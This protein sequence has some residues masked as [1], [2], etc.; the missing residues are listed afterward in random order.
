MAIKPKKERDFRAE[1]QRRLQRGRERNLS[2]SQS[3]GHHRAGERDLSGP[4]AHQPNTPLERALRLVKSGATQKAAARQVGITP[5]RLRRFMKENTTAFREGRRWVVLDERPVA[6]TMATRGEQQDVTV[7][8]AAA[9]DIGRHWNAVNR[10][11]DT[12][13]QIFLQSFDG[14]GVRDVSGKFHPYETRPN[15]LRKLDAIG[16][17]SFIDIYADVAK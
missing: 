6:V 12:N 9:S 2:I 16:E 15:V 14:M 10:F 4:A 11:L 8:P 7:S 1:Y 17:L 5:E 13:S 3:R